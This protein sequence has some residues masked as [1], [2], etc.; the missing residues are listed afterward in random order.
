MGMSQLLFTIKGKSP[1]DAAL[2]KP[3]R[4]QLQPEKYENAHR[5]NMD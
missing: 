2:N 1:A 5:K 4:L 3:L